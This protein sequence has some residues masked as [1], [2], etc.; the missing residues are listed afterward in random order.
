[1]L[2]N[3]LALFL[4]AAALP[5]Q[6]AHQ[7]RQPVEPV[8]IPP[9][10]QQGVDLIYIDPEIAPLLRRRDA[11][12]G[13]LGLE[14]R[15]GAAIDLVVPVH[16]L[17]TEIRRGLMRYRAAWG[18]LP[19]VQIP[20]GPALK[21]G[22]ASERVELLRERLGLTPGNRFDEA[23]GKALRN[24]QQAHGLKPDGIAGAGT[25]DALNLGPSH[26]EQLAMINLERARRL[27]G[28]SE[29]GRYV[30]VDAG[31]ARLYMYD[32]GKLQDSM[33]V[34]VGK[35]ASAT[36]MMAG[37]IR[38]ASINPYWNVPTD[39]AQTLIA[40]RVLAEGLG[41][42]KAERYQILDGWAHDA[43]VVDPAAVDWA[44]VASGK[45]EIRVRQLPGRGNSMGEIKFMMPNDYG[46]YLHDTPDKA[47]F[48]SDDRWLSNGCIRVEN[49]RRLA[50]WLFGRMPT[51]ADP[52]A[53]EDVALAAPVPVYV[54][55]LTVGASQQG[56]VFR[57]DP[58]SRDPAVLARYFSSGAGLKL[59]G[60]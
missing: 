24:F 51:G 34:I 60:R 16:P 11:L 6:A 33:K 12:L 30:L 47:L 45:Q 40:P 25:I 56:L 37:L 32:D 59:T 3:H 42:V 28:P 17:Y 27:P 55:Y 39:L 8:E 15:P 41:H 9:S 53:E 49:A 10:I 46:I 58:Y 57:K 35:S 2:L 5:G 19:D 22:A 29:P 43:A 44:A 13:E 38:Y 1:M 14:D 7:R 20:A 48:K 23:L 54:T 31:G 52:D 18:G 36:P 21:P 26:F 50:A 4:L